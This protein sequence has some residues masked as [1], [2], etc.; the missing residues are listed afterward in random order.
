[1]MI[2]DWVHWGLWT[3]LMVLLIWSMFWSRR[4]AREARKGLLRARLHRERVLFRDD[5]EVDV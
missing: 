4:A 1:M 5:E 3:V 2:S